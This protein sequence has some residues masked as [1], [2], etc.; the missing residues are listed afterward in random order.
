[1]PGVETL[2]VLIQHPSPFD[3]KSLRLAGKELASAL[4][5]NL[6]HSVNLFYDKKD[7]NKNAYWKSGLEEALLSLVSKELLKI[8][9]VSNETIISNKD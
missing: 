4:S 9:D 8:V 1:M 2:N 7:R 3:Q 6:V 5:K